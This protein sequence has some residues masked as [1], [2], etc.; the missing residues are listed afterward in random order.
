MRILHD[1]P[2]F[3]CDLYRGE[4]N[5]I[6]RYNGTLDTV[7]LTTCKCFERSNHICWLMHSNTQGDPD[8]SDGQ[9]LLKKRDPE[10]G[11]PADRGTQAVSDMSKL[12]V[13]LSHDSHRV[14]QQNFDH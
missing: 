11:Y 12:V 13:S 6:E 3:E 7:T 1:P 4:H 9:E 14:H 8:D 10:V 2:Q 5:S